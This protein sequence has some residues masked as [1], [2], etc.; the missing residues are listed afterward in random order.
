MIE[1]ILKYYH[2]CYFNNPHR[3][4]IKLALWKFGKNSY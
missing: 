4:I 3:D 1:V 2:R